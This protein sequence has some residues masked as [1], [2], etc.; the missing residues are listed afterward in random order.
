MHIE[1][2]RK[3]G[4]VIGELD[5]DLRAIAACPVCGRPTCGVVP[6]GQSAEEAGLC[7]GRHS[8]DDRGPR[9]DFW[10]R[11]GQVQAGMCA[12]VEGGH[13][14][15]ARRVE[16]RLRFARNAYVEASVRA[17]SPE[18]VERE[19]LRAFRWLLEAERELAT[20]SARTREALAG[21]TP[22]LPRIGGAGPG[23]ARP[24]GAGARGRGGRARR[25]VR[26][27]TGPDGDALVHADL[28]APAVPVAGAQRDAAD[29]ARL[30]DAEP[31]AGP[32]GV[33]GA[34]RD[35]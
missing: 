18:R 33:C 30:A 11:E 32:A 12:L 21:G 2:L 3:L 26:L 7:T 31:L 16:R 23:D 5:R 4:Q 27:A 22:S 29:G 35:Q 24:G 25:G 14:R 1:E 6:R 15:E 19:T 10:R 34:G 28:A 9:E 8:L 20:C 13:E 17:A